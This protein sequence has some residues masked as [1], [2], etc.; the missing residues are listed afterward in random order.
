MS[1]ILKYE[2]IKKNGKIS[3]IKASKLR[4]VHS[5]FKKEFKYEEKRGKNSKHF[6]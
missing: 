4:E 2:N 6:S 1:P 5:K 3:E